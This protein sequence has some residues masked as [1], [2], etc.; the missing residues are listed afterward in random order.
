MKLHYCKL[1]LFSDIKMNIYQI[2]PDNT[3]DARV[4]LFIFY[5]WCNKILFYL[6]WRSDGH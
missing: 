1:D 6:L 4:E 5:C 2:F 3:E